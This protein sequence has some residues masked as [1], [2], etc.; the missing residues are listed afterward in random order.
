MSNAVH[1][2]IYKLKK[3]ASIPDFLLAIETLVN[4]EISK[5]KGYVSCTLMVDG[6]T[7]IDAATFET[8]EDL[9]KFEDESRNPSELASHFYSFI[10][11]TAKGNRHHKLSIERSFKSE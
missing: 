6:E 3:D 7:W 10:N 11:F 2:N 8:E 5:K 9:K 4:E 1:F